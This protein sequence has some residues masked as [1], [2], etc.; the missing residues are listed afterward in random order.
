[1]PGVINCYNNMHMSEKPP[2]FDPQGTKA[3]QQHH[4]AAFLFP[5]EVQR[6]CVQDP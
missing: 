5:F 1:M 2:Q 6:D 3:K 4:L